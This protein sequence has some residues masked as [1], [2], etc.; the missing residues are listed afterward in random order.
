MNL[1]LDTSALVKFYVEEAGSGLVR[2]SIRDARS[3][4]T[5]TIT[6]P[7]MSA[8][9][10]R[11][12]RMGLASRDLVERTR[13]RFREDWPGF[14]RIAVSEDLA[15]LADDLAWSHGIRGYDAVHLAAALS[16]NRR[17]GGPVSFVCFDRQ[18]WR[19]AQAEGLSCVPSDL[20]EWLAGQR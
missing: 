11:I 10:S 16:W 19:A 17:L 15:A 20:P 5:A 9:F 8:A 1:Y 12:T 6:R 3:L 18:L 4:S 2:D 13:Q 14:L 7:E